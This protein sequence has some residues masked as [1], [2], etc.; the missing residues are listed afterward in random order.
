MV[1]MWSVQRGGEK[2]CRGRDGREREVG[3]PIGGEGSEQGVKNQKTKRKKK[4]EKVF[5]QAIAGAWLRGPAAK[6]DVGKKTVSAAKK[7]L[8]GKRL[9]SKRACP[10][11][12]ITGRKPDPGRPSKGGGKRL[13]TGAGA[14]TIDTGARS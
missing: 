6:R 1:T 8:G 5:P 10:S 12:V 4:K 14:I 9:E 3:G 11:T 13:R 2:N 7:I